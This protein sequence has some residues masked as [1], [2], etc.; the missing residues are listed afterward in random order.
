MLDVAQ[1]WELD[2]ERGPNWLFVRLKGLPECPEDEDLLEGQV[3]ELL[4][5]HLAHRLVI[6]LDGLDRL[7]DRCVGQ[8]VQLYDRV[9][10]HDGVM[11]LCGLSPGQRR[12]LRH[13][14]TEQR[15]PIYRDREEAVF[16]VHRAFQPR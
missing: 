9:Q 1:G 15:L 16:G 11:R 6:E 4:E 2:V 13:Y 12:V 8:L 3:W 10:A 14:D 7:D 5:E